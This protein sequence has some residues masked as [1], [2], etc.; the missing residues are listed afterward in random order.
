MNSSDGCP[1][2]LSL[3]IFCCIML[4]AANEAT[5][6]GKDETNR[7]FCVLLSF[8]FAVKVVSETSLIQNELL[9]IFVFSTA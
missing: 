4:V 6:R 7:Y 1:A 2:A 3:Y 9:F 8:C 5:D